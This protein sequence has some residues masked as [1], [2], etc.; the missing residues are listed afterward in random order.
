[1]SGLF[2]PCLQNL[3]QA[4]EKLLKALLIEFYLKFLKTHSINALVA[5]LNDAEVIMDIS[6]E[7]CDFLDSIYLPSKYPL[8]GVIPDFE[9][10]LNVCKQC[11][12]IAKRVRNSVSFH[13]SKTAGM[14]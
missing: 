2:N 12:D 8:G 7:E 11:I 1:M 9:P 6:T 13:L 5:S 3:Q 4:V 10:D 14:K